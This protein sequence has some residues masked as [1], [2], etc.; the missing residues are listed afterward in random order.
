MKTWGYLFLI[1]MAIGCEDVIDLDIPEEDPRLIVDALIRIDPDAFVIRFGVQ[2]NETSG[3]F[4]EIPATNLKQIT[5]GGLV[6]QDTAN[7]GSGLYENYLAPVG[8][9]KEEVVFQVQHKDQRYLARAIYQD[10]SPIE[11]LK[12]GPG[13]TFNDNTEVII[14]FKDDPEAENFYLFDFDQKNYMVSSDKFYNG[15]NYEFSYKYNK[16]IEPGTEITVS[17]LG[18]DRSFFNY[19]NI[20]IN[21]T[22]EETDLFD[23]PVSTLRGNIINVTEIDN[24]DYFDNVDQTNNFALGYFALAQTYTK[25]LVI[26]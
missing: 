14:S 12:Q 19:M 1:F 4:G 16:K 25:T 24:I 10:S 6:L 23:T 13:N 7:P 5:M 15:Q 26:E 20:V 9:T 2:V 3:F 22:K 8:L 11:T 17:I 18:I 21:Q